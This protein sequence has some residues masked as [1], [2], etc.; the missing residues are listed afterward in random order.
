MS[1]TAFILQN[2]RRADEKHKVAL[3]VALLKLPL[4][5][6]SHRI[7]AARTFSPRELPLATMGIAKTGFLKDT[8]SLP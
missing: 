4:K 3:T 5:F 1:P 8:W 7:V 6:I 2:N